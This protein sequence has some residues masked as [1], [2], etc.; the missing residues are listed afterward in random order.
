GIPPDVLPRIF[1][2]FYSS[3]T[4]YS[5]GLGVGLSFVRSALGRMQATIHCRSVLGEFTEFTLQFPPV[6]EGDD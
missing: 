6:R 3:A 2:R 5:T 4:D 1:E